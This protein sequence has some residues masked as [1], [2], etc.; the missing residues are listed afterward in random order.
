MHGISL[1][2]QWELDPGN[3]DTTI[4]L[5]SLSLNT[6]YDFRVKTYFQPGGPCPSSNSW[7]D[8]SFTTAKC[9]NT[10]STDTQEHCDSYTFRWK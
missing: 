6:S 10:Y 9:L 5:N 8:V 2:L 7:F 1:E 4:Q 3:P